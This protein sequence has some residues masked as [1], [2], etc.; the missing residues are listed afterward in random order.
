[1]V[2]DRANATATSEITLS[3]DDLREVAGYAAACAEDVLEIFES[4][5]PADSGL[6]DAID[7]AWAFARGGRRGKVLVPGGCH[8]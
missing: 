5:H 2:R 6:R 4:A 3:M 8:A 7:A 1:M